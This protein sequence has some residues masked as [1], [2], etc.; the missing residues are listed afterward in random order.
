SMIR[1]QQRV[2][3]L[4]QR[5]HLPRQLV[6]RRRSIRSERHTTQRQY[7]FRKYRL[8]DRETRNGERGAVWRMCMTHCLNLGTLTIDQEM[9]RKL[10]RRTSIVQS[11]AVE[12]RD[13]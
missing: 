11:A 6:S 2:V 9:H 7:N 13:R 4:H 12:V 3:M 5:L 8:I 1:H 10:A